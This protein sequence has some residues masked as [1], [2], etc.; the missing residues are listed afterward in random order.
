MSLKVLLPFDVFLEKAGVS[1]IAAEGAGGC[2]G[3]LPHRRDCVAALAPG[4][5]TYQVED[6]AETYLALDEGILVKVGPQVFVSVRRAQAGA[7]LG[8][9]RQSV[10]TEFLRRDARDR[11][12]RQVMAKL[13][14]GLLQRMAALGHA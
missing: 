13:E 12:L 8:H 2:F 6:E 1:R 5:L 11:S 7:D 4:I 14:A 9:L 3:L 10:Q